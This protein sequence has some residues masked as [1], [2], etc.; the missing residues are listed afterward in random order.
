[1]RTCLHT[2]QQQTA[3]LPSIEPGAW[4]VHG[5]ATVSLHCTVTKDEPT[6]RAASVTVDPARLLWGAMIHAGVKGEDMAAVAE[7]EE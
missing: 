2:L 3:W 6:S 7:Q 1:M 5:T 4:P